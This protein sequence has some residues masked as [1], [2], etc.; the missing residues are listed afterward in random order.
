L[1]SAIA[2]ALGTERVRYCQWKGHFRQD[3]WTSGKGDMDL[4]VAP[5]SV[6]RFLEVLQVAGFIQTIGPDDY[7]LLGT[8]HYR[9]LDPD[10]GR[11][12]HIHVHSRLLI[13]SARGFVYRLPFENALIASSR[14]GPLFRTPAPDLE[15]LVLVL[16]TNLRWASWRVVPKDTREELAYLEGLVDPR[17]QVEML[18]RHLRAVSPEL[19]RRCRAA[20]E[21][22]ATLGDRWRARSDLTRA[23]AAYARRP[24]GWER[25]SHAAAAAAWHLRGGPRL[26]SRARPS[27]GGRL[28]AIS[29]TD[30]S[31]KSTCT[32]ALANWLR[33][34]MHVKTFHIGRPPRSL[35]TF[36]VGALHRVMPGR[37]MYWLRLLCTA[38]DR[39]RLVQRAWDFA[40]DGGIALTERYPMAPNSRLVGPWIRISAGSPLKPI[41]ERLARMEERYYARMPQ[42]DRVFVLDVDPDIAVRRKT[43]EPSDYVRSRAELMQRADWSGINA[44][45]IDASRP[46]ENVIAD[47][48][49][50]VWE[51]L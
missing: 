41:A 34:Q 14:P 13:E 32:A 1:L 19:Y 48:R 31:G 35:L 30:G 18:R 24:T 22:Q 26:A 51:A 3:R 9:A 23:L 46:L 5:E 4:L 37:T 50:L 7:K 40:L 25:I 11:M 45:R 6:P 2:E 15:A 36:V 20:L 47:L 28:F 12:L 29:G 21:P 27:N 44:R 42:P 39:Y 38:R 49:K 33:P 10:S 8:A 16:R 17:Y 43:D